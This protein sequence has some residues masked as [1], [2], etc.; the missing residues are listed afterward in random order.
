MRVIKFNPLLEIKFRAYLLKSTLNLPALRALRFVL[1]VAPY[2]S[3]SR[4]FLQCSR[5]HVVE[6]LNGYF[7]VLVEF[8]IKFLQNF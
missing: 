2:L 3:L 4:D 5:L 8:Y 1:A 7:C 6:F